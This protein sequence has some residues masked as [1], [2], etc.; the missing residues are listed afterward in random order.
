MTRGAVER[1]VS[2]KARGLIA[3]VENTAIMFKND[4]TTRVQEREALEAYIARLEAIAAKA[5]VDLVAQR[6]R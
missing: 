6:H 2:D 3:A 5:Q 1:V 4:D